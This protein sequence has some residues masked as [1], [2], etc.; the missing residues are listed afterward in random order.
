MTNLPAVI[1]PTF[2][3]MRDPTLL[4]ADFR[5]KVQNAA[6]SDPLNPLNLFNIG[7]KS[8]DPA[9]KLTN[10]VVLPKALT[11]VD[12]N[13]VVIMG[14]HFP[15]GSHKVGP[16][17]SCL[18]EKQLS[19]AIKPGQHRAIF[20]ST[21]NYGIGGAWTGPRM[22]YKSLV[23]LPEEMSAER[24]VKIRGYGA[25][26][27]ATPGC[28]SNV[29]EIYDK[30]WELRADPE[31]HVLNQF[32]EFGNYRFHY[33]VTGE[34]IESLVKHLEGQGIGN[35]RTAAF[36]SAMGSAGTIGAADYLKAKDDHV[37]IVG[38]E[39]VQCPTLYN[40]GFGGH[41]IEGI[42]DKHVTWIHNVMNMDYLMCIDDDSCVRGLSLVQE[43][44]QWLVSELGL[45]EAEAESISGVFGVSGICN[46]LGAIKTAKTLNL[47]CNDVIVTVATDGFDRYPSVLKNL[48]EE[49]GALDRDQFLRRISIF[50]G[51]STDYV[52]EGSRAVRER[53]HNQKYFTWVE[54][55]KRS[56]EDLRALADQDFWAAEAAKIADVN[57][58]ILKAR[59]DLA[60]WE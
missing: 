44:P 35:G 8:H 34:A 58:A 14:R 27:I 6:K 39:P 28:E 45:T 59:G 30:V 24:F 23:V 18:I 32:E 29:K 10:H 51:L 38:L 5:A 26:I 7:W 60:N 4:P 55:Q 16:A 47:G 1:G 15:S 25:D 57:K 33:G 20:P 54:Q 53:W 11:G 9:G 2:D 17:Y 37:R 56:V 48:A 49:E 12:A 13:I 36:I 40:V 22:N 46:V 42:G 19:G 3:E 21:G 50:H 41:K 31:N 43:G 52:Q